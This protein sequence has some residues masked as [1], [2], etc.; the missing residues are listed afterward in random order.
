MARR[1]AALV[2]TLINRDVPRHADG[3]TRAILAH[4]AHSARCTLGGGTAVRTAIE[5]G[6]PSSRAPTPVVRSRTAGSWTRWRPH[7]GA[8]MTVGAASWR[9]ASGWA[10]H[11]LRVGQPADLVV[12]RD[13]PRADPS[14]P[15]ASPRS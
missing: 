5:P 1:A 9:R 8:T 15:R 4:A 11:P 10:A 13:D 2:P 7:D 14:A 6:W 12:Y 3:A